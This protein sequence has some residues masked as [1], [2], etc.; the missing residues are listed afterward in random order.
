[1]RLLL[2][3]VLS[4][5]LVLAF[6]CVP[7]TALAEYPS[8]PITLVAPYGPG[9]ASD[10]A[11]RTL[12]AAVNKYIGQPVV[13]INRTGAGG[14]TG[15]AYVS[16]RAGDGYTLLLG[17]VGCSC[18]VPALNKTIP[19]KWDDFTFI[20]MLELNPFVYVV[21]AD[22]PYKTLKELTD[23][24]K[25][26]PGKLSFSNSGPY[27]L[28]AM[29]SYMLIDAAGLPQKAATGIP[30]KGGGAAKTALM[31]GHVNFLGINLAPVL[32]QIQAGTL[33]ALAVTTPERYP[34]IKD[35][36]TVREAG[37]PSLEPAIGWSALL[38]PPN[39]DPAAVEKWKKALAEIKKDKA[40]NKITKSLGS[41]P[42]IT[43]GPAC[44]AYIKKMYETYDGLGQKMGITI[45]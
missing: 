4:F 40:W 19:Y 25:K 12:A 39:M 9:G 3:R 41:I 29:G 22:S 30:Y 34:A 17:R 32:D 33:R 28:L 20:G 5:A 42:Y 8:K 35:V 21:K 6:V 14:V 15:S 44:K 7:M 18:L 11:A 13:V 23:D 27:G 38:G 37:F 43:D 1:M 45:K 2:T 26:N 36:P 24:M 10:L 16:K 31:G